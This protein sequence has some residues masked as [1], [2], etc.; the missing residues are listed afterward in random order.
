MRVIGDASMLLAR[1][2]ADD[3]AAAKRARRNFDDD[4]MELVSNPLPSFTHRH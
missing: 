4:D 1:P 3:T 2:Q